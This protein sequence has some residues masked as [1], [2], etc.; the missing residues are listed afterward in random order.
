MDIVK[1][2]PFPAIFGPLSKSYCFYFYIL[3]FVGFFFLILTLVT[4]LYVGIVKRKGPEFYYQS[5]LI[6]IVYGVFY[7][8]NRL[9]YNICGKAL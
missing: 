6:A 2:P 4:S 7:L 3:A 1:N 8:Q 9:L 5:L